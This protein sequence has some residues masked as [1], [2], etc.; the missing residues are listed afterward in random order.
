MGIKPKDI[1]RV[2]GLT[3][4]TIYYYNR[5]YKP[6]KARMPELLKKLGEKI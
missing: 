6:A 2:T 1:A 3:I 4:F 5:Q